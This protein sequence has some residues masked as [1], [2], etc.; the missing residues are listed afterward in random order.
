MSKNMQVVAKQVKTLWG[1][2]GALRV[3]MLTGCLPPVIGSSPDIIIPGV[4]PLNQCL[5]YSEKIQACKRQ[6]VDRKMWKLR[7]TVFNKHAAS[8]IW[9]ISLL[10]SSFFGLLF[11]FSLRDVHV[12]NREGRTEWRSPIP[13]P[14]PPAGMLWGLAHRCFKSLLTTLAQESPIGHIL[15]AWGNSQRPLCC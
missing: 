15:A 12:L 5:N 7:L 1:R 14:Q 2:E 6:T 3:W 9:R 13:Q 8:A 4:A 11:G 10:V